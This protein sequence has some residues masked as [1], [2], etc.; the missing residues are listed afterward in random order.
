MLIILFWIIS[1]ALVCCYAKEQNL[2]LSSA[3]QSRKVVHQHGCITYF[4]NT[5]SKG[6]RLQGISTAHLSHPVA[7][8]IELV[9]K[10]FT[11]CSNQRLLT[12][13]FIRQSK[14]HTTGKNGLEQAFPTHRQASRQALGH[15][16]RVPRSSSFFRV[17]IYIYIYIYIYMYIYMCKYT[18]TYIYIYICVYICECKEE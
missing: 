7:N 1:K 10:L 18:N 16:R 17:Y 13:V 4:Q 12:I 5:L 9:E 3:M 2:A 11:P 6:Q 14:K 15:G 8:K